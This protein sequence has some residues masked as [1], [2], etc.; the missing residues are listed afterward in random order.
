MRFR[1]LRD[2]RREAQ[3]NANRDDEPF[4]LI[5]DGLDI[6]PVP[7]RLKYSFLLSE[8]HKGSEPLDGEEF[9]PAPTGVRV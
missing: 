1:D 2:K 8:K 7:K 5:R 9:Y 6:E 3:A 4:V